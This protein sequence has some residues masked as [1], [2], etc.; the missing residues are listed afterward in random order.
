MW[1]KTWL[2]PF[3]V[4]L[5]SLCIIISNSTHFMANVKISSLLWLN[6]NICVYRPHFCYLF[7]HWWT[8]RLIPHHCYSELCGNKPISVGVQVSFICKLVQPLWKIVSKYCKNI[9]HMTPLSRFW[10]DIQRKWTQQLME[11]SFHACLLAAIKE[12]TNNGRWKMKY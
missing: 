12:N 9:H 1:E 4:W 11:L 2:L 10:Q 6:N 7:N 5:I 3:Y 8:S